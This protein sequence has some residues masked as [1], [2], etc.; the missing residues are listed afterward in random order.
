MKFRWWILRRAK[1]NGI[2]VHYV[3]EVLPNS[4]HY[5]VGYEFIAIFMAIMR[6]QK[7]YLSYNCCIW[8]HSSALCIFSDP[9]YYIR[10]TKTNE[11]MSV[12]IPQL[13]T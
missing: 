10:N 11:S 1:T 9:K 3:F 5:A 6:N 4:Q 12:K 7:S 8:K 2:N 13:Q